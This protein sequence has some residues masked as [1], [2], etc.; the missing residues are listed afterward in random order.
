MAQALGQEKRFAGP[1]KPRMQGP[2]TVLRSGFGLIETDKLAKV[3]IL[4]GCLIQGGADRLGHRP[5]RLP[6][7]TDQAGRPLRVLTFSSTDPKPISHGGD[8]RTQCPVPSPQ[9]EH[10]DGPSLLEAHGWPVR[11]TQRLRPFFYPASIAYGLIVAARNWAFD[12]GFLAAGRLPVP[13]F[14][15][16]NLT[17]GG[18][19]KTPMA[20]WLAHQIQGLGLRPA[21]LSRG[22]GGPVGLLPEGVPGNDEALVIARHLPQVAH[23]QGADRRS[24]AIE[25]LAHR[26]ADALIL[27][28]GFQH[29][30]V[31]RDMDIVMV[32]AGNPWGN[33]CLLPAGPL[34]EPLT[35]LR[36]AQVAVLTHCDQVASDRLARIE[37][38]LRRNNPQL[39]V[40]KSIHEARTLV[41]WEGGTAPLSALQGRCVTVLCGIGDP[42]SFLRQLVTLGAHIHSAIVFPDHF[43]Y[44]QARRQY[45]EAFVQRLP[46]NR[47]L[48]T[49]EK[50]LVKLATPSI[51]GRPL[52]ALQI[53]LRIV[54]GEAELVARIRQTICRKRNSE[55]RAAAPRVRAA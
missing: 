47:W 12:R 38:S 35:S 53:A 3:C 25:L 29:R 49:T 10:C 15:V 23:R 43:R 50:D 7:W 39:L 54:E 8:R 22:Y 36:R 20:I 51:A 11:A 33:G 34:R 24:K 4:L 1:K 16:G 55:I 48:L 26:A 9:P 27:D 19:G 2:T 14:S 37:R 5:G 40:V 41:A 31:G 44:T 28:D 6:R 52:L 18:T 13:V 17:V 30:Q 21:L 42:S 45:L 46:V 32:H